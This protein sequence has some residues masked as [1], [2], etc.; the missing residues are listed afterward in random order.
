[1]ER[2]NAS[3][4]G[5]ASAFDQSFLLKP[6]YDAGDVTS[7]AV[8]QVTEVLHGLRRQVVKPQQGKCLHAG[9]VVRKPC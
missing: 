3:V 6:I 8:Q 4:P 9:E 5:V 2:F 7:I 1:M